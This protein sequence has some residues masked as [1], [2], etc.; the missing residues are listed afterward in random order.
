MQEPTSQSSLL[1]GCRVVWIGYIVG[2]IV[3]WNASLCNGYLCISLFY[4][5]KNVVQRRAHVD[6]VVSLISSKI[7]VIGIV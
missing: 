3:Y 5:C 6:T 4:E 7:L 2:T 1:L